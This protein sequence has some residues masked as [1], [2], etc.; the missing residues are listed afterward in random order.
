MQNSDVATPLPWRRH[1]RNLLYRSQTF[2]ICQ[3]PRLGGTLQPL[4][5]GVL[6]REPTVTQPGSERS[7]PSTARHGL[8]TFR[9]S[10]SCSVE[11]YLPSLD[12][13]PIIRNPQVRKAW[14][15]LSLG[16]FQVR[17]HA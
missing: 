12:L 13:L 4:K 5:N 16:H 1:W 7:L 3:E 2:G 11:S 6:C 15:G 8:W 9:E 10:E 14:V 17:F